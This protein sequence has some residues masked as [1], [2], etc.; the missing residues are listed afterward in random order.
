MERVNKKL[1]GKEGEDLAANYLTGLGYEIIQR[2]FRAGRK[3][4]DIVAFDGKELVFVEVKAGRAKEFGEPE[5][6]VDE[7]KQKNLAEVAQKFLA[8]T[9][10][11][12]ES[13]RFDVVGVDLG[14]KKII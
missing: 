7:R 11:E 1:S 2:N 9:S 3:E 12:F 4:I 10:V 14:T 6:R 5:L 8:E 13:C